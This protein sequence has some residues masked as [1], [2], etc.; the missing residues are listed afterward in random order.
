MFS[1][2]TYRMRK[3][4]QNFKKTN[5]WKDAAK[6][7]RPLKAQLQTDQAANRRVSPSVANRFCVAGSH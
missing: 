3:K 7:K 2:E 1:S 6:E 4:F 5:K